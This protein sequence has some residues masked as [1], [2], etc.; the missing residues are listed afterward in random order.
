M[1]EEKD[2][3]NIGKKLRTHFSQKLL[4]YFKNPYFLLFSLLFI[5]AL[6]IRF[7]YLFQDS[8]WNDET[9]YMWNALR[10]LENPFFLFSSQFIGDVVVFPNLVIAFFAIF[11]KIFVAGRLM[12]LFFAMSGIVLIY[13]IGKEVKDES[14]GL[15]AAI[16]LTFHHL[17]WFLGD[18]ALVDVPLATMFTLGAY[19]IIKFEKHHNKK[20]AWIL[21]IASILIILTK[22]IGFLFFIIM[23]LYLLIT[24]KTKIIKDK[25][26]LKM[27]AIPFTF[28]IFAG[29][30]YGFI[31]KRFLL[32]SF[33]EKLWQLN[34]VA[35]PTNYINSF[36][37]FVLNKYV[38]VIF[39][40]GL[41]LLLI[42]RQKHHI[43]FLIWFLFYLAFF[44]FS[45]TGQ[46]LPRFLAPIFPVAFLIT[47]EALYEIRMFLNGLIKFNIPKLLFVVIAI[48]LI[49]PFYTQGVAMHEGRYFTFSGYQ[50]AGEWLKI[51]SE[52]NAIIITTAPRQIRAFAEREFQE[53]YEVEYGGTLNY[54]NKFK[55]LD[56][57]IN[58]INKIDAP[59]YL[60][61]DI[62]ES[63]Q[64]DWVSPMT[65]DKANALGSLGFQ[66]V[67][68]VNR[69][70]PTNVGIQKGPIGFIF[71]KG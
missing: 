56:E 60:H 4:N 30:V 8:I 37:G 19:C 50:E 6:T 49:L 42:Y 54:A 9:V 7:K 22:S 31:F 17:Y 61:S 2:I 10:I 65:Q 38:A 71:R 52:P 34:G 26:T 58:E 68:V 33:F 39:V 44:E 21:G 64:P 23:L 40:I 29:I 25:L 32:Y 43:L 1:D 67:Y 3:E 14:V 45:I 48:L 20:W 57:F 5:V 47:A 12:G 15:M 63:G 27:L 36:F 55:T 28:L 35:D 13:L 66:L 16:L 11:F 70:I 18:K 53:H 24:K 41:I 46:T 62:W 69:D 59:V 51:N